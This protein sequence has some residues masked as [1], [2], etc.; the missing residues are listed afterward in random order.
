MSSRSWIYTLNNYTDE[1]IQQLKAFTVRRHRSCK[2]VGESATA[3]LQGA[4]TFTRN[5]RLSQLKKLNPK[6]HWEISRCKD[7]ENY[8]TKGEIIIDVQPEQGKRNDLQIAISAIESRQSIVDIARSA[9]PVYIKYHKG[10]LAYRNAIQPRITQFTKPYVHVI[11]GEPGSGKTKMVFESGKEIY[12]VMEPINGSLWFDGYE[13]HEAILLDDF[14]GWIKYHTLLQLL[15]G[16]PMQL[17]IKGSTVWKNWTTVFITSNK[18]PSQ[19]YTRDE[20]DALTRRISQITE[21][22]KCL[23]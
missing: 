6:I 21:L 3:H 11:F 13:G 14:Y 17:P 10:L 2:E 9:P 12:N 18:H 19:W 22:H 5:Y 16:Y 8:C 4:I 20:I 1:D 23:I 15:D 7:A